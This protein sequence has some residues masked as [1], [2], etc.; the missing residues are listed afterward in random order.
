MTRVLSG[1]KSAASNATF[2]TTVYFPC[3]RMFHCHLIDLRI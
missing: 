3:R 2:T 1:V